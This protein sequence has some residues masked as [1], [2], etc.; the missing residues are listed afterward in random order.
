MAD[1]RTYIKLHDGMP[2]HP[3]VVGLSDKAFRAYI[4]ALCYCSEY[5]TDGKV[6]ASNLTKIAPRR[7]WRELSEA[8]LIHDADSGIAMHDYLEHQRSADQVKDLKEKRRAS[9]QR[10][11]RAKA[12]AVA[13]ATHDAS[14]PPEQTGSKSLAETESLTYVR[15][16]T[17]TDNSSLRSESTRKRATRIA[18]DF[19]PSPELAAWTLTQGFTAGQGRTLVAEFVDYWT[20]KAGRDATKTDWDATFRNWVRRADPQRVRAPGPVAPIWDP[21]VT[22]IRGTQREDAMWNP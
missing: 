3:K 22:P 21:V 18:A 9:G 15:D 17:E 5:L 20:A 8:G 6:P 19:T 10:G 2:R 11:G 4:E 16:Q 14:D 1:D 12:N 13:S 7:V